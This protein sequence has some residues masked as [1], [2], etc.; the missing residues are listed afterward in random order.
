MDCI[1]HAMLV[2]GGGGY[3]TCMTTYDD[4]TDT[5]MRGTEHLHIVGG[6]RNNIII[7]SME[8]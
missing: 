1:M 8:A 6:R 4:D 2:D 5:I 3:W 7:I